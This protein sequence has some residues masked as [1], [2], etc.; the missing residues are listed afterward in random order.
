[1]AHAIVVATLLGLA[2]LLSILS[3]LGLAVMRD[4]YQRLHYP[5]V[6]V[7]WASIFIIV[8]VWI[9]EKDPQARIKAILI[10]LLLFTMNSVLTSA[11]A[12]AI[13]IQDKGHWEPHPDEGIEVVGQKQVAG[14]TGAT[15][16]HEA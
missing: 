9:D 3:A 16:E 12:K 11:T 14:A 10:G 7:S 2:V 15:E 8:A 13:R 6:I 4:A 1:M 5:A